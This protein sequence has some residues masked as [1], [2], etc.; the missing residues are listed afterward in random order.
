MLAIT[1]DCEESDDALEE[2]EVGAV[3]AGF[4]QA[5][6]GLQ[7]GAVRQERGGRQEG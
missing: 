6:Q 4:E 7:Q 2:Q 5:V 3:G 1:A